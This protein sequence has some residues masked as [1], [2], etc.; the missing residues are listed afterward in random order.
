MNDRSEESTNIQIGVELSDEDIYDAMSHI[1]G[2]VDI[3]TED[4]RKIYHLAFRHAVESLTSRICARDVMTP[5]LQAV[6]PQ[7]ALD[8]AAEIMARQ[9]LKSI[10]V[11]DS[12]NR[13][14]GVLSEADYL[15]RLG[16][17]TFTG[18]LIQLLDN[19]GRICEECH[20][21]TVAS[22]MSTPPVTVPED[23]NFQ[24]LMQTFKLHPVRRVPVVDGAG[25]LQGIIARKDF[26]SA[27][28]LET[29]E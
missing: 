3:T 26:I 8:E 24:T 27:C 29:F 2:Y 28:R 20:Q 23:A 14:V 6:R 15:K 21:T 25:K 17:D 1:S 10:P 22:V 9:G 4:F 18:F 5:G 16:V 7:M 19:P 13:V 11:V 12:D